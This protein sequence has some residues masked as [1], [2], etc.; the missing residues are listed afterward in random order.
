[1]QLLGEPERS[2]ILMEHSAKN[3]AVL[4]E[5]S[6]SLAWLFS[7]FIVDELHQGTCNPYCNCSQHWYKVNRCW[8]SCFTEGGITAQGQVFKLTACS[9]ELKQEVAQKEDA[10]AVVFGSYFPEVWTLEKESYVGQVVRD[11]CTE[12]DGTTWAGPKPTTAWGW[13][14]TA[15]AVEVGRGRKE[16]LE[17]TRKNHEKT[18]SIPHKSSL[19]LTKL[20]R[21]IPAA[22][23]QAVAVIIG[24]SL[25]V[26]LW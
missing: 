18:L 21:C 6:I 11:P 26:W 13:D 5:N 3:I 7:T 22:C 12:M 23:S 20:H 9:T 1:M 15:M 19:L 25:L 16:H 24:C 8:I 10:W 2:R 17:A 14:A 4:K